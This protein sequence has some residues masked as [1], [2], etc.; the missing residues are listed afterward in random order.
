MIEVNGEPLDWHEGLTVRGVLAARN[1]RFP[2][3]VVTV[4]GTLI[5]REDYDRAL[6]PDG[7]KVSVLH[8]MSGG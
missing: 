6:V 1:Y 5:R 8:L 3:L 4:D 7:A 2:L